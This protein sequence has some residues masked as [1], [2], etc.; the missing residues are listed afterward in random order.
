MKITKKMAEESKVAVRKHRHDALDMLKELEDKGEAS[1][2]DCE[3]A[4]KKVEDTVGDGVK[5]IDEIQAHK[6]KDI[7]EI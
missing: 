6:E 2:D 4:R 3:R 5:K 1:E 7:T